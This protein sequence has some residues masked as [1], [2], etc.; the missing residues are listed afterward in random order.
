[1]EIVSSEPAFIE[2]T[3][4]YFSLLNITGEAEGVT[5]KN[6]KY[7][8]ENAAIECDYQYGVSNEIL[9]GKV[10]GVSVAKGRL[11]LIKVI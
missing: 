4:S 9:P 3:Y 7:P 8:L 11:L 10:A 1:M 6:A 5:I 2:D